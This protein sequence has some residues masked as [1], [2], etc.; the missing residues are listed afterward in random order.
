MLELAQQKGLAEGYEINSVIFDDPL[1]GQAALAGARF[2]AHILPQVVFPTQAEDRRVVVVGP[3]TGLQ[4]ARVTQASRASVLGDLATGDPGRFVIDWTGLQRAPGEWDEWDG[5]WS[6]E[7][8]RL[9]RQIMDAA[10]IGM[11]RGWQMQV[12]GP[13]PRSRAPLFRT[14]SGVFEEVGA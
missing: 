8:M 12:L 7:N 11:D 6:I 2:D 14:V 4:G 3:G 10:R 1:G 5:L 9:N 13:V